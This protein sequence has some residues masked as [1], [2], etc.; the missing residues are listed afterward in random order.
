V[1]V[2]LGLVHLC[3]RA[4]LAPVEPKEA[5]TTCLFAAVAPDGAGLV[6]Q[7]GDGLVLVGDGVNSEPLTQRP[8]GSFANETLGLGVTHHLAAWHWRRLAPGAHRLLLCT[9]GVADDLLPER[10]PALLDWIEQDML[11]LP[12]SSRWRTLA[13]ELRAW[14]TPRHSDD[15]TL[16]FLRSCP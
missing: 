11:P 15:K 16:A 3:W 14:P 13:R 7:L 5:A 1:E 9:D 10:Y 6:A 2:L 8:E 4:R 12:P